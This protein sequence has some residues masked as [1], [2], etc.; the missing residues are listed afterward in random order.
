MAFQSSSP[1]ELSVSSHLLSGKSPFSSFSHHLPRRD[2]PRVTE[3]HLGGVPLPLV[4]LPPS[5]HPEW[6]H[7]HCSLLGDPTGFPSLQGAP[8][9][10]LKCSG[11][12]PAL[13]SAVPHS[14]ITPCPRIIY[15]WGC[16]A[17][18]SGLSTRAACASAAQQGP[19]TGSPPPPPPRLRRGGA[20]GTALGSLLG[21][22]RPGPP[23]PE[24]GTIR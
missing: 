8:A 24:C 2:V 4:T 12:V 18:F 22:I 11:S 19:N 5:R 15:K 16:T 17:S 23:G 20:G 7:V 14:H 21:S 3:C 10:F 9:E 13:V 6:V 1:S